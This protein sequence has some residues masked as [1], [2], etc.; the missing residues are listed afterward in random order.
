MP[1]EPYQLKT[2]FSFGSSTVRIVFG[3]IFN[4][5]PGIVEAALVSSDDNY[6]TMHTGVSGSLREK[7]GNVYVQE[8][9]AKCP[10]EAGTVLCT[11]LSNLKDYPKNFENKLP[12]NVDYVF[13]AAVIDYDR[14]DR[15]IEDIVEAAT[16]N[17]LNRAE[18]LGIA[19]LIFPLMGAGGAGEDQVRRCARAMAMAI[20]AYLAQERPVKEAVLVL[21]DASAAADQERQARNLSIIQEINLVLDVPYNPLLPGSQARDLY[22]RQDLLGQLTAVLNDSV[23]GKRHMLVLGGPKSGKWALLDQLFLETQ[24]SGSPLAKDRFFAKVTFGRIYENTSLAFVYRKLIIAMARYEQNNELRQRILDSYASREV[25]CTEFI[26]LVKKEYK[27]KEIVFL[28]DELPDLLKL[29][30]DETPRPGD[31]RLFWADLDQLDR[32]VRFFIPYET[33]S[34][35]LSCFSVWSGSV[36]VFKRKSRLFG[37][38]VSARSSAPRGSASCTA[39]IFS[40]TVIFHIKFMTSLQQRPVCTRICSAWRHITWLKVSSGSGYST[41]VQAMTWTTGL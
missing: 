37:F 6:L 39:A 7:L 29:R 36:K 4:T 27:G 17:C 9:Q 33:N 20:K 41:P 8:L 14:S 26:E 16:T 22:G 11:R 31:I 13:H 1:G 35:I 18:D 21:R 15:Q 30:P 25:G 40:P 2:T 32:Y 12:E 38:P 5:I 19:S 34:K 28:L 3:D 23:P 24:A 10:V